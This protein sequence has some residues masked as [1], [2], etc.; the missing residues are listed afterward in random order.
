MNYYEVLGVSKNATENELKKQYRALSYKYHP[1]RNPTGSEH[2]QKV[3]EAYET[4]KDPMKR[5]E[6]D[7]SFTNPL[8]ILLEK[9]FR[10]KDKDPIEELF[11]SDFYHEKIEDLETKIELSFKE[12]YNGTQFP[13]NIKRCVN[14]GRTKC[15]ENEK[16]YLDIPAGIDDGEI[17]KLKEKGNCNNGHYSDLKI[18]IKVLPHEFFE[19]KGMDLIYR[20]YITFK[21]SICGFEGS[22][23]HLNDISLKLQSSRGNIIQNYDERVIKNKGFIRDQD[24]GNLIIV[25]RVNVPSKLSETQLTALESVFQ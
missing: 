7:M 4:L 14:Q 2:M 5:Q 24:I 6:Y 19:R 20:K 15:Y 21:E 11:K 10:S 17:L 8:D 23:L 18:H 25:F 13:I 3:N 9:M 12:S 22:I 1:D 16:I